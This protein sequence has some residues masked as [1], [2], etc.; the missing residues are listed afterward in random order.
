MATDLE[1]VDTYSYFRSDMY[2]AKGSLSLPVASA[3]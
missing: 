2:F 3:S 1:M